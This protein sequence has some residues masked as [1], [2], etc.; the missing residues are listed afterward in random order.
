MNVNSG[1]QEAQNL[2]HPLVVQACKKK[3]PEGFSPVKQFAYVK[4]LD[5]IK[6]QLYAQHKK[7]NVVVSMGHFQRFKDHVEFL[8]EGAMVFL[9][10]ARRAKVR[11]KIEVNGKLVEASDPDWSTEC[12]NCG[13]VPTEINTTLCG[14]CL[15]GEKG[16]ANGHW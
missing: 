4:N 10:D 7:E 15:F 2:A 3:A 8:K 16:A 1:I 11:K 6:K 12:K 14:P 9:R 5:K 13:A